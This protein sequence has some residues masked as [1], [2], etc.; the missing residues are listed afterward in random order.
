M[1]PNL[2]VTNIQ[3]FHSFI[4]HSC[5][6]CP[7]RII[8]TP[9]T[10]SPDSAGA[11]PHELLHAPEPGGHAQVR[12]TVQPLCGAGGARVPP[13]A[14]ATHN[15]ACRRNPDTFP[16][17]AFPLFFTELFFKSQFKMTPSK[18]KTKFLNF[19]VPSR[20]FLD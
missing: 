11:Q 12:D 5:W 19:K 20:F 15:A 14:M 2:R 4:S 18:K 17:E 7:L 8:L 13:V 10:A 3:C 16:G 6:H 1:Y 9:G